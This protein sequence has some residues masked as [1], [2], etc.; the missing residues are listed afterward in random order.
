MDQQPRPLQRFHKH[1]VAETAIAKTVRREKATGLIVSSTAS[2]GAI[3]LDAIQKPYPLYFLQNSLWVNDP[4]LNDWIESVYEL[5]NSHAEIALSYVILRAI[6]ALG[7]NLLT[8]CGQQLGLILRREHAPFIGK[9][10]NLIEVEIAIQ[11]RRKG[12]DFLR[13]HGL[14]FLHRGDFA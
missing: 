1:P 2:Y 4:R 13:H 9:P 3:F 6:S 7:F 14:V 8:R 12:I 5:A 10:G 11:V